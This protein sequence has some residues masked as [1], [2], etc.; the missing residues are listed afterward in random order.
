MIFRCPICGEEFEEIGK[1]FV[2]KKN[3]LFDISSSG[4]VNLLPVHKA[5][6]K[7]PG[8]SEEM[9]SARR[10]FLSKGYYEPLMRGII[11]LI[12]SRLPRSGIILDCGCGEGYYT[13]AMAEAFLERGANVYG[14]DISKTAVKKAAK[15][16]KL[17]MERTGNETVKQ[18]ENKSDKNK[19]DKSVKGRIEGKIKENA[20]EKIEER[21]EGRTEERIEK[22]FEGRT[23]EKNRGN[24]EGSVGEKTEGEI[25]VKAEEKHGEETVET[26][27]TADFGSESFEVGDSGDV[28][29]AVASVYDLPVNDE[30]ADVVTDVFSPLAISE[31]RRVLK[32]GGFFLYVVPGERHL[33][34]MKSTLYDRPYENEFSMPDYDGFYYEKVEKISFPL[35][36][37][38][39]E[40]IMSLFNMTPYFWRTPREG[41]ERL[42]G[43][44]RLEDTAEFYIYLL[45]KSV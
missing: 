4:Y 35:I 10:N 39:K 24:P 22:K 32:N 17:V 33:I 7:A 15:R 18:E 20:E 6:S 44:S 37:E 1:S 45:R 43:K 30:S 13:V 19:S 16:A 42:K 23:E 25:K 14:V 11:E 26:V 36:I 21:A 34:E 41:V 38:E 8:D 9:V 3:H 28:F 27:G 29:F 31:Y 12:S 40:D 5:N 2:C